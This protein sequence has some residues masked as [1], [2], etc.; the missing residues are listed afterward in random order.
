MVLLLFK[1]LELTKCFESFKESIGNS[2]HPDNVL[3]LFGY[4]LFY[5]FKYVFSSAETLVQVLSSFVNTTGYNLF[6]FL[7]FI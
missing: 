4:H 5:V 3:F 1:T 7:V 2:S 6:A